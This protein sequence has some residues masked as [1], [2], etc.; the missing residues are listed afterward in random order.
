VRYRY[1]PGIWD[2][3]DYKQLLWPKATAKLPNA[4]IKAPDAMTIVRLIQFETEVSH[5][6][7]FAMPMRPLPSFTVMF[8]PP[9][10]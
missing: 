3:A 4:V 10:G 2:R 6:D 8:V 9:K 1:V 7:I 5:F